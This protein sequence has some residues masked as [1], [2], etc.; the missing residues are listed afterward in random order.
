MGARKRSQS[1][2][3]SRGLKAR[4]RSRV[5]GLGAG[6]SA[7]LALGLSPLAAAPAAHAD[8]FGI[9]SI[10]DPIITAMTNVDPALS[11]GL[12][13][14]ATSLD[15]ALGSLS[16]VDPTTGL[17]HWGA[18]LDAALGSLSSADQTAGLDS[19]IGRA[20]V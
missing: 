20:H 7:F 5:I 10:L 13:H 17:D 6:A 18:S 12:D 3:R 15:A 9:D 16:S 11:V 8:E 14:W 4:R 1:T 19:K 2:G